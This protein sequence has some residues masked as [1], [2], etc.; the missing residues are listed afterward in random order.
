MSHITVAIDGPSGAGK[1]TAAR[2]AAAR[3]GMI[4]ADT[5]AIYRSIAYKALS[6]GV[7]I[8]DERAVGEFLPSVRP[9]L[10]FVD[11]EQRV[12]VNGED[13]SDKI[14][15]PEISMATS[16]ISAYPA[17]REFLLGLQRELAAKNDVIMDGRDIGTVVLPDATL[18]IFLTA[19][20][21]KRADR[22]CKELAEKG[23]PQ[24]YDDVLKDIIKRDYDDSHRQTAPLRQ[25][26]DA[27]LLDTGDMSLEESVDA[28]C[29]LIKTKS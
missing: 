28:V 1:S 8:S 21:E 5:G 16:K 13:V 29:A 22:R 2:A 18:K 27:V 20:A 19:S 12:L 3:L 14:R 4:Y 17:V 26:P 11:G 25:A 6:E 7:D 15:T 23:T 10:R 24:A 9:E